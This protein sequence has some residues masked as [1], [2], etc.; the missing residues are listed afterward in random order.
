[1]GG[2]GEGWGGGGGHWDK[3]KKRLKRIVV[4][5]FGLSGEA[6]GW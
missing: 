6:L 4:S 1:M 3:R 5:R 2:A